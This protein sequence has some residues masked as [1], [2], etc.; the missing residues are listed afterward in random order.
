MFALK[1]RQSIFK[2]FL[3]TL[4]VLTLFAGGGIAAAQVDTKDFRIIFPAMWNEALDPILSAGVGS[5]GLAAI[6]DNLV[7]AKEDGSA[8]SKENGLARDW[9]VSPDGKI[10]TFY[11]RKGIQFHR[12]F[13]ELTAEDVKFSFERVRSE[14]SVAQRRSYFKN[15][16]GRI[17]VVDKYTLKVYAAKVPIPDFITYASPLQ[18]STE[19]FIVSKRAVEQLGENGFATNP[20]GTGPYRFVKHIGGQYIQLE[21]VENHWRLK[22]PRF[23]TVRFMAVPE[24]ETSIAM[25]ARG[26]ADVV[27][28]GRA[29]IK[30]LQKKGTS[31]VLQKGA[32]TIQL[33]MDDIFVENVPVHKEKV[34][35]ALN[36]AVD[37]QAIVDT[38]FE[39]N[40][41]PLGTYYTQTAVLDGLGYNWR[42]DLYPY[43]PKKARQLLK[44]AGYPNGFKMDVY[45]Y[46]WSGI[47]EAP[48]LMQAVVGMWEAI[49]VKV[50]INSTEYGVV[51]KKLLKNEIPGASGYFPGPNRPWQGMLGV[52]RIFMHS[53]GAFSHVQFKELDGY[54]DTASRA[55]DPEIAKANLRKAAKYIRKHHLSVP[56]LQFDLSFGISDRAK[57]WDPG[58]LPQNLNYDSMFRR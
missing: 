23:K 36:L 49:G 15:K 41:R 24:E 32:F 30:R 21:A 3:S 19:R 52:Y 5:I 56:I 6:Y 4:T 26:E 18:A 35:E 17:E 27:P 33:F 31:V 47:P 10:W 42:E 44:Q 40:G 38:I 48:E 22:T 29:N 11:L 13:G 37:R 43:D 12:D 58:F 54:L 34:R 16:V 7:G 53:K 45:I 25:L 28:I 2:K 46:P 57:H 55:I 50:N 51:R 8:L 39:G 20:V 9:N 1:M 14:R